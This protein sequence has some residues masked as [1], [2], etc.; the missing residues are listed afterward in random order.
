MPQHAVEHIRLEHRVEAHAGEPDAIV[1]EHV[2]LTL[3]VVAQLRDLRILENRPQ[4]GEYLLA[5]ELRR[6][7]GIVMP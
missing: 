5:I 3:D 4:R 1:R 7:T 6:R 2:G